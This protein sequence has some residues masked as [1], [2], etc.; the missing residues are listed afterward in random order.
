L[1]WRVYGT[2]RPSLPLETKR[3][4]EEVQRHRSDVRRLETDF[5]AGFG[6]LAE[7]LRSWRETIGSGR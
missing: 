7:D 6:L 3:A 4:L 5:P 1:K 2:D